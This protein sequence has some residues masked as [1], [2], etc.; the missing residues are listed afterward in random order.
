M[1]RRRCKAAPSSKNHLQ[2]AQNFPAIENIRG[3]KRKE[4]GE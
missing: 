1:E 2:L 3:W 4:E